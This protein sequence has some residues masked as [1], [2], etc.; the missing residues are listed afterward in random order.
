MNVSNAMI[1]CMVCYPF[2]IAWIIYKNRFQDYLF[3]AL[4]VCL[5]II[6]SFIAYKSFDGALSYLHAAAVGFAGVIVPC[7]FALSIM[8]ILTRRGE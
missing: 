1:L 4:T 8:N 5:G 7:V 6:F 2:I 3:F